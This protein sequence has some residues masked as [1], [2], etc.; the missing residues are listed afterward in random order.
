MQLQSSKENNSENNICSTGKAERIE[1]GFVTHSD[2]SNGKDN[3][4]SLRPATPTPKP[5]KEYT[6]EPTQIQVPH[7]AGSTDQ[8]ALLPNS[9]LP[10]LIP[11]FPPIFP[12]QIPTA[13]TGSF[14]Q[15][16]F[17]ME[18][19]FPYSSVLPQAL[20]GLS[21]GSILQ[22]YQHNLQGA[23]M[24][25][26]LQLQQ[27]QLL[28]QPQKT[29]ASQISAPAHCKEVAYNKD[30][31]LDSSKPEENQGT[32]YEESSPSCSSGSTKQLDEGFLISQCI[33]SK[34]TCNE[35]GKDVCPYDCLACKISLY[36]NE[37]LIQHLEEHQHRQR[38][39]EQLNAKERAS[40]LL[41]HVSS[42]STSQ[43]NPPGD[44][45]S[46]T[47]SQ[48]ALESPSA[49]S[50]T[51]STSVAQCSQSPSTSTALSGA[52]QLS[53]SQANASLPPLPSI[54]TS[55]LPGHASSCHLKPTDSSDGCSS[56]DGSSEEQEST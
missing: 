19:M 52:T 45:I 41:P 32:S 23:L 42:S 48:S 16:M 51:Q 35:R 4:E 8:S 56:N 6:M 13:L 10:C 11:G 27:K 55:S 24:H 50:S 31:V 43:P 47:V 44:Q 54:V 46:P 25:H 30:P 2:S 12:P 1:I 9:L 22:Q 26:H 7:G 18:G 53:C 20:M 34:G 5:D 29:K 36:G 38:V 39:A 37:K 28:Q 15:P 14:L 33:V 3:Q 21:P 17:G 49:T 40:R